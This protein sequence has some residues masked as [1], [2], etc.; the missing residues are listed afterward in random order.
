MIENYK[1]IYNQVYSR[2]LLDK[3]LKYYN[4]QFKV[5]GSK[6]GKQYV[7][8]CPFHDDS[9]PSFSVQEK[10][11]LYNCFV[12]GGGDFFK[13]VKNLE[14]FNS[15]KQAIDFTKRQVGLSECVDVF[16]IVSNSTFQYFDDKE[17]SLEDDEFVEVR[18]P[19]SFAAEDYFE[20]V[21]KRVTIEDVKKYGMRYCVDD[22]VYHE[23]LVIPVYMFGKLIT[24]AARDM[25]GKA[26]IWSNVKDILK[27]KK[28]T[29]EE[30]Q[31]FVDQYMYKKILY[32]YGTPMG[33]AFFNWDE[34]VK[35]KK[36]VFICEGIF[37]ALKIIKF[38]YNAIALLSCHLNPYKSKMLIKNF[39][40]IYVTLDND[41]KVDVFGNH[42]NPGQEAAKKLID[43]YLTDIPVFNLLLP[44]GK[45][46]DDCTREEFEDALKRAKNKKNLFT[47]DNF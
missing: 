45:D 15:I 2:I 38:G 29:K 40:S 4:I 36:E 21:K 37:D 39:D 35:N 42:S 9:T 30:K 1:A 41:N 13:L 14:N 27:T 12:C 23:R 47:L 5:Y 28:I 31:R 16:S 43:M 25:S 7:S 46:P 17:D 33:R 8:V 10:T 32:P 19:D 24:F 26:D 34:A 44:V 20:I 18:L 22:R 6:K 11:G 3:F